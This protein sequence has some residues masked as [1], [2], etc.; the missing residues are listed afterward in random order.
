MN[1]KVMKEAL[2]LHFNYVF[3]ILYENAL[4]IKIENAEIITQ[5]KNISAWA[6]ITHF[7]H[8]QSPFFISTFL[9]NISAALK[10]RGLTFDTSSCEVDFE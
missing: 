7:W 2:V 9:D 6:N 4:I 5:A 10:L 3:Q 8:T 1:K